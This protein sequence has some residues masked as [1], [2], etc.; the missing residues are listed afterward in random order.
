MCLQSFT[1]GTAFLDVMREAWECIA[2]HN[3]FLFAAPTAHFTKLHFITPAC[4]NASAPIVQ[5]GLPGACVTPSLMNSYY[6]PSIWHVPVAFVE[7]MLSD[8]DIMHNCKPHR[9]A[10]NAGPE[11]IIK[12][13]LHCC[14]PIRHHGNHG[15]QIPCK[16]DTNCNHSNQI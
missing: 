1:P 7:C 9:D 3:K 14:F 4:M 16:Q 5:L 12:N 2:V 15:D 13:Q 6:R 11:L 10:N 8:S